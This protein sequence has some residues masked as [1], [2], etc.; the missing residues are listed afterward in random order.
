M[1]IQIRN[2][3][4]ADA[5]VV[6]DLSRQLGYPDALPETKQYI[7]DVLG[8]PDHVA[9]VAIADEKIVGWIHGFKARHLV[10]KPYVEVGGLVVDKDYR[11]K[12]IGKQLLEQVK[13]WAADKDVVHLR[14]RSNTIRND[15]HR[16][17]LNLGF[18]E[19][20]EQKVFEVSL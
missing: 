16:F 4:P 9:Y 5:D 19:I 11:N 17:Y 12:K 8:V 18:V 3:V 10:G 1:E 14:V 15:A 13:I 2:M 7:A 6:N 20:K